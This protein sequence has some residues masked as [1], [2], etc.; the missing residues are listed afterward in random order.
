MLRYRD[1][2]IKLNILHSTAKKDAFFNVRHS[3]LAQI[4]TWMRFCDKYLNNDNEQ[5]CVFIFLLFSGG[6]H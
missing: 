4:L 6:I 5:M 3:F 1:N 2:V